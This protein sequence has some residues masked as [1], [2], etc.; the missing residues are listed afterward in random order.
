LS[1]TGR[2]SKTY[3]L[4]LHAYQAGSSMH[5]PE[6]DTSDRSK[7][8]GASF[9]DVRPARGCSP[10][11]A[12]R[13]SLVVAPY[14]GDA[15]ALARWL[16][17]SG[18]DA[19]DVVQD[20]SIRALQGIDKFANG[21][22]RAWLLAIVRNAAYDWLRKNRSKSMVFVDD[23]EELEGTQGAE[24]DIRALEAA[25]LKN[26]EAT[27]IESAI[28]ALP[29]HYRET[30]VLREVQGLSYRDIAELTGISIGTTMSRLFRARRLVI[31]QLK[32]SSG[33]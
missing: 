3:L 24:P 10:D 23:L 7:A 28:L 13:F 14:L 18:P 20:A 33:S 29:L 16:T 26:E 6:A 30:L 4:H 25:L 9:Q 11:A 27:R 32:N 19:E 31:E 22:A 15:Y 5:S 17:G 1:R 8:P 12:A 2:C 21:S